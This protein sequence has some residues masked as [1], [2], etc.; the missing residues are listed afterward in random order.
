M[1]KRPFATIQLD[2]GRYSDESKPLV[3]LFVSP[4]AIAAEP[5]Y[6]YKAA[7]VTV[8]VRMPTGEYS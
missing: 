8:A 5:T 6:D 1:A 7:V 2:L 4:S 3:P